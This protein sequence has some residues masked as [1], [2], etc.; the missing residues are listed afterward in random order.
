MTMLYKWQVQSKK[1]SKGDNKYIDSVNWKV[2][3]PTD[4]KLDDGS[5]V[6]IDMTEL[7]DTTTKELDETR[8]KVISD[9][10]AQ[11]EAE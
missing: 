2:G 10:Q 4:I 1:F 11:L 8:G 5:V 6:V 9:Y 7:L 3:I